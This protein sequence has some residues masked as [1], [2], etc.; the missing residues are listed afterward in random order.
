MK[1]NELRLGNWWDNGEGG[2][3]IIDNSTMIDF[4]NEAWEKNGEVN[5]DPIPLT[6]QW[7][8]DFGFKKYE[9]N[10][11][12]WGHEKGYVINNE[13][14]NQLSDYFR[15]YWRDKPMQTWVDEL[16][17][18]KEDD[19]GSNFYIYVNQN[20]ARSVF[21]VHQLQNLYFALTGKELMKK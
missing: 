9:D 4:L 10:K 21:Y 11:Q 18:H 19:K 3:Y 13:L 2:Q 7:L 5:I 14:K 12:D 8:K 1:A 20:Y 6:E 16:W 17:P 15:V